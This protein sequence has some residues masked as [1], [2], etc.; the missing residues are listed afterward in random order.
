MVTVTF[1]T[2][3]QMAGAVKDVLEAALTPYVAGPPVT[4]VKQVYG[5]DELYEG[6]NEWPAIEVYVEDWE[7]SYDSDLD[8]TVF[9][10]DGDKRSITNCHIHV[11]VYAARRNQLNE[12]WRDALVLANAV[13][14]VL[15]DE[16]ACPLFDLAGMHD[17]HWTASRVVFS[18]A[19]AEYCGYR[20][21]LTVKVY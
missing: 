9:C 21:I 5:Y 13:N 7:L 10:Q 19:Q 11:D 6:M 20:F 3:Q 12:N 14:A 2:F 18:R 1:V 16:C 8:R 15:E 17:L 4:T